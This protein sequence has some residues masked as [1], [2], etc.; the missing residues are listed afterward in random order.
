MKKKF[1]LLII[2]PTY[3]PAYHIGGPIFQISK[4]SSLLNKKKINHKIL[5]TKKSFDKGGKKN[6]KTIYFNSYFG[7][8]YFSINLI[9]FLIKEIK[10]YDKIY[11]VSCFNF[12]TLFSS[13]ICNLFNKDYLISPRGSLMKKSIDFKSKFIKKIWIFFFEKRIISKAKK[14]IF[15]SKFEEF[16]TKK[17][18]TVK[19]SIIINNFLTIL[20]SV[21]TKK[22]LN[23]LLFLGRITKK[24]NIEKLIYAYKKQFNFQ[25]K[26]LGSGEEQYINILRNIIKERNL[27]D[28]IYLLPPIYKEVNKKKLFQEAR[29]SI[30]LS[31]TENFGNT[32]LE[33]LLCKTPV[34]ITKNTGLSVL[35]KRK[36]L[37][38]ICENKVSSLNKVY[39]NI[40]NGFNVKINKKKHEEI[41]KL[42]NDKQTIKKYV[43]LFN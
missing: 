28:K 26:I 12:F 21:A 25:I 17:I 10:N 6:N 42:F 7:S 37:G 24:K 15:S 35:I 19:N 32:I 36:K 33:S 39:K 16:E 41:K 27:E 2:T 4:L 11:I 23:Y 30:L 22:K 14:I 8:L 18:V 40:N 20:P 38:I 9:F 29:F 34:I 5:S 31:S 13:I 3:L 43:K 1:N